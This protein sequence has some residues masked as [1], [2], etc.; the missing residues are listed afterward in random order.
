MTQ[1][2]LRKLQPEDMQQVVAIYNSNQVFLLNH[3]GTG[4]ISLDFIRQEA[5]VMAKAGFHS[6]VIVSAENQAVLGVLDH[7]PDR[8]AYLSLLMLAQDRQGQGLGR[9]IY[10]LCESEM[11][12][13]GCEAIRI[14]VVCDYAGN[15]L[16]FW[17][18][19]GFS[20]CEHVA[21]KWGGKQSRAVVMRKIIKENNKA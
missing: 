5:A 10:Q 17:Q 4:S 18:S 15:L 13:L 12:R 19:L 9:S 21:L 11:Q 7:R 1:Y 6:C 16:P 8:E 14:D 2:L 20:A 3:L